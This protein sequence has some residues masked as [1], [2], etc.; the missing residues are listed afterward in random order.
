MNVLDAAAGG[1]VG[2]E[3]DLDELLSL[4][5]LLLNLELFCLHDSLC[6]LLLLAV[7]DGDD[8]LD[9]L[10]ALD[11]LDTD[12]C[13][14]SN[15]TFSTELF[16]DNFF[17]LS[18]VSSGS[19]P[20]VGLGPQELTELLDDPALCD[21]A[22]RGGDDE[23]DDSDIVVDKDLAIF[24]LDFILPPLIF[25]FFIAEDSDDEEEDDL[26]SRR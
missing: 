26:I 19:S 18:C 2:L 7:L 14:D 9:S 1:I 10:D 16:S 5:L 13:D 15:D 24:N 21:L 3:L 22:G 20:V 11:T 6:D 17:N 8:E 12:D 23:D 4:L 25:I